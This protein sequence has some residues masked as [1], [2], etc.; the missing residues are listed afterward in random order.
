VTLNQG[1]D[2]TGNSNK[3]VQNTRDDVDVN[4]V[5]LRAQADA[6][7]PA[8]NNNVNSRYIL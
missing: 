1:R 6:S 7:M 2:V 5:E 4:V 8:S 3:I